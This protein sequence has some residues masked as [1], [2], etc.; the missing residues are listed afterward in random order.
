MLIVDSQI[1]LWNG[2]QSPPHH[3]QGYFL[4]EDA[5]AE[6][7]A[8]GITAAI[9]HP[10]MWDQASNTYAIDAAR[11]FPDRFATL[12]WLNLAEPEAPERVRRWRDQPGMIGLRLLCMLPHEQ[13]WPTD[14]TMNWLWPL[15]EE[16]GLPIA[17][18]G[19]KLLNLINDLAPRH[20]GLKLTVDHLGWIGPGADPAVFNQIPNLHEWARHPNVA[21]KLTGL[22]DYATDDYPFRSMHE[23]VRRLYDAYGPE[24]LFWGT[25]IT[26]LK[27][28]WRSCVTLFQ[29]EMPWLSES[30]KILIFG[31]AFCAWHDW[32]PGG[33]S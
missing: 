23:V 3:R 6:M 11:R 7:D 21:V 4:A 1:H 8:A 14:G 19:P 20:P 13:N 10:P 28:S 26:R 2:G 17:L 31:E 18:A 25:D 22:P 29:E 30:D 32:R 16:I 24:R 33:S 12:G 15:A 5:V 27:T 9:N